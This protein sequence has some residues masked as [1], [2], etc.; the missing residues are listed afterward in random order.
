[1]YP[2]PNSILRYSRLVHEL[3]EDGT[4]SGSMPVL[5]DH[6]DAGGA[7]RLGALAP[8]VDL[9]AGILGARAA[10]PDLTATLD[11]KVHLVEPPRSG[12]AHGFAVPLRAGST[13]VLSENR[14]QDDAGNLVGVAQVT[15]SRLPRRPGSA[16]HPPPKTRRVD[17]TH[18]DEEP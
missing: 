16:Q 1:R 5:P 13:T 4:V 14:L 17:Y 7:M 9:C 3:H 6:L 10:H 8:L 12:R 2:H 18:P 15:F 11:F